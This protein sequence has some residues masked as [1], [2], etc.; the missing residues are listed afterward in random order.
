MK[1]LFNLFID[2]F[3]RNKF[4]ILI[5]MGLLTSLEI[6]MM[7]IYSLNKINNSNYE[8]SLS[9]YFYDNKLFYI[10]LGVGM[11]GILIFTWYSWYREWMLQGRHIYRLMTLP[12]SRIPIAWSKWA[13]IL[14]TVVTMIAW[15][16]LIMIIFDFTFDTFV[17]NYH[18]IGFKNDL[19]FNAGGLNLLIPVNVLSLLESLSIF[20]LVILVISNC[21]I[22][23]LSYK[24]QS[25][26]KAIGWNILYLTLSVFLV[27]LAFYFL[28]R[29]VDGTGFEVNLVFFFIVLVFNLIHGCFMTWL[30][31]FKLSI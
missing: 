22:L 23:F 21:Q 15:Q 3:N 5:F 27:G 18:S 12:G 4:F 2:E 10:I 26:F 9:T 28:T 29:F 7:I 25:T 8:L 16:A 13:A 11:V 30:S 19:A 24:S 20:S 31:R 1:K 17:D 14:L 6:V